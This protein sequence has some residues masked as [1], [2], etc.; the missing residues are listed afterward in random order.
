MP[1]Q[2]TEKLSQPKILVIDDDLMQQK[3]M[4]ANISAYGYACETASTG[5]EGLEKARL[6][7]P[8]VIILDLFLPDMSG[9]TACKQLRAKKETR[10]IP[11][12]SVTSSEDKRVRLDSLNA[13]ANDFIN[14][15]VDFIELRIKI[16][17]LVQMKGFE[18]IKVKHDILA[19]TIDL[20]ETAKREWEQSMDCIRDA[21]LL[22]DSNGLILRC[23]KVL[24]TLTG[25]T[26]KELINCR[27][28]DIIAEGGFQ[29]LFRSR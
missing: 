19:K 12:I 2:E 21:V 15:P 17:N 20:I 24:S 9:I 4:S 5:T 14:K 26:Y 6:N 16:R 22:A 7:D 23:N 3:I 18:D 29:Q 8:D 1:L 11:I 28:H 25:K 27:W 13:G 10:H